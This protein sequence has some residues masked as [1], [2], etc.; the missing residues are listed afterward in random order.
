MAAPTLS[1]LLASTAS[2]AD[3]SSYTTGSITPTAGRLVLAA[4]AA[5]DNPSSLQQPTCSGC[6]LTWTAIRAALIA[7]GTG[8]GQVMLVVFAAY[9]DPLVVT[10][11]GL[12]FSNAV[13]SGICDG[14]L[15]SVYEVADWLPHGGSTAGTGLVNINSNSVTADSMNVNGSA[16][17]NAD[18]LV[19]SWC[20]TYNDGSSTAPTLT[21]PTGWT[22]LTNTACSLGSEA[23][24]LGAAYNTS[25][26]AGADWS[27]SSTN[28]RM[29]GL[30]A[31][32]LGNPGPVAARQRVYDQAVHQ[33]SRW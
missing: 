1:T 22:G 8:T 33:A 31:E 2:T 15:W 26:D 24:R 19:I 4:F 29:L 11:G 32:V 21:N 7:A 14:A 13:S 5:G 6:G 3:Q 23:M 17:Q 30:L 28:D 12:T 27:A 20:L 16:V 10:S 25:S 18:S 9:A